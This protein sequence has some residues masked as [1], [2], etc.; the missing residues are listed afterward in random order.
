[1]FTKLH[2]GRYIRTAL[3][4]MI[5]VNKH[6]FKTKVGKWREGQGCTIFILREG[7]GVEYIANNVGGGV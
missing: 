5:N 3:T 1:M 2:Q 7:G 4:N 6:I